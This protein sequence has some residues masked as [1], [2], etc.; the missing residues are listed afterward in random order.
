M[1]KKEIVKQI[2]D[3]MELT[4]LQVKD[5]VQKTFDSIVETLLREKR[6]EFADHLQHAR[7][8]ERFQVAVLLR[9]V[10]GR[11]H[12][13]R[14]VGGED[15]LHPDFFLGVRKVGGCSK[16]E[17]GCGQRRRRSGQA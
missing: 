11:V 17:R 13:A 1:T 12:A 6:I 8:P 16:R 9:A 2:S 10:T 15:E 4:Q 5:I 3:N 14:Y 7:V